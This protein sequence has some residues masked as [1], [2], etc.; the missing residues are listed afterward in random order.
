MLKWGA[1][2]IRGVQLE[3]DP[4]LRHWIDWPAYQAERQMEVLGLGEPA[5]GME[6]LSFTEV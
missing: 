3:L 1:Y 6:A 4:D 5:L 2:V